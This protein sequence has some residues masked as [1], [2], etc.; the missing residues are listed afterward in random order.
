M[1]VIVHTP[2]GLVK[3]AVETVT[4]RLFEDMK[5]E[6]ARAAQGEYLEF[7]TEDGWAVV[8]A[9]QIWYIE[10]SLF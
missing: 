4:E 2:G 5:I 1:Q 9:S 7:N 6:L 3:S 10:I 8:P